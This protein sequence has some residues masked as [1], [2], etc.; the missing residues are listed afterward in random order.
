MAFSL[1]FPTKTLYT[2]LLSP[3]YATC[4]T[5]LILLNLITRTLLSEQYRPLSSSLCSFL[6]SP[7]TSSLVVPNILRSTLF[8]NTL[9]LR[10]SLNVSDQVSHPYKTKGKLWFQ[11]NVV[12]LKI[13]CLSLLEALDHS[14]IVRMLPIAQRRKI[15]TENLGKIIC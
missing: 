15:K 5:H 12:L 1:G 8:S 4:L 14:K 10:S 2:S 6:H 13:K 7:V 3:I 11:G 9:S